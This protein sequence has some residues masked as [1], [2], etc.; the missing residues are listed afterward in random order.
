[1]TWYKVTNDFKCR[2]CRKPGSIEYR[3]L[4][5]IYEDYEYHCRACGKYWRVDGSDY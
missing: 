4:G 2:Y 1:M 3:E 5:D